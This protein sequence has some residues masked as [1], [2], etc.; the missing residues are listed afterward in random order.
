MTHKVYLL[1]KNHA[2][3]HKRRFSLIFACRVSAAAMMMFI[4]TIFTLLHLVS[5]MPLVVCL[6]CENCNDIELSFNNAMEFPS[7]C[8]QQ[9]IEADVC[10][11]TFH[12]N[13]L[14]RKGWT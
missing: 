2:R 8:E 10:Q 3:L 9:L 12:T 5:S 4:K 1:S 6:L 14:T 11:A 13:Y 7:R